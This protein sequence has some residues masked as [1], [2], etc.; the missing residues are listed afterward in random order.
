MHTRGR[1]GGRGEGKYSTPLRKNFKTLINKNAINP[2]IGGPPRQ[3]FL[4]ALTPLGILATNNR[5]PLPWIF[6]PCASMD[7]L[8]FMHK[9]KEIYFF[10]FFYLK[11]YLFRK[12]I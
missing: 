4:K 6:N 9:R 7:K 11:K 1:G 10:N 12:N 5:Y 3:F 8:L 2:K